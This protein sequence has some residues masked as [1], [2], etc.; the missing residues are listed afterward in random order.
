MGSISGPPATQ[1]LVDSLAGLKLEDVPASA[2]SVARH[3]LVDWFGCALAG[4]REPLSQILIHET[5]AR[6]PG[7]TT[8]A[9]RPERTTPLTAALVNG[10]MSHALDFDDTHWTMNGHPSVPVVPAVLALAE[11]EGSDGAAF[12]AA[13]I[14]GI[15]F[16]CRL[17]ALIGAPHYAAGFHA[18]GT[19]GTFGAAAAAA[20]LLGLDRVEWCHAIGLAGTQAAGLKSGFG[21]MA[22]PLHAGRAASNGLLAALLARGGFTG[23]PAIIETAQGFAATHAGG[24]IDAGRLARIGER[25]LITE[26]LFKYHASCY[27][28]HAPIEAASQLRGQGLRAAEIESVQVRG[29][30]TCVGVCDIAEPSTGLEGK[31]SLRATTAMA[32]LGDDTSDPATFSDERMRDTDLR[33]VRDRVAFAPVE[34]M[35]ATRATVAVRAGGRELTAEADTGSPANDLEAQ[36]SKLSAKFFALAE[37]VIGR[38]NAR[39]LHSAIADIEDVPSVRDLASLLRPAAAA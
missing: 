25:W 9:G 10:A 39:A 27:L 37:P 4:S 15:E 26:T 1:A 14:A 20:H 3:C 34:G 18:T 16:E 31:F 30:T 32:L 2:R 38:E 5:A 28:T 23:N 33:A 7:K 13:V 12:L 22:K 29:S 6:E 19:L 8:L 36:W 24:A 35:P 11:Q 21:T 17:G